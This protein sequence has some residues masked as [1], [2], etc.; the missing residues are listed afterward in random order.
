MPKPAA[1]KQRK[2]VKLD[3]KILALKKKL[4]EEAEKA[5]AER[6]ARLAAG[7]VPMT[8]E[9]RREADKEQKR[10][11]EEAAA[12]AAEF[13][14]TKIIASQI[15]QSAA[16]SAAAAEA[17]QMIAAAAL[18]GSHARKGHKENAA[19]ARNAYLNYAERFHRNNPNYN[20][21]G[22]R[23]YTLKGKFAKK[24]AKGGKRGLTRRK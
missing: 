13:E 10:L 6:S 11:E 21:G 2:E 8:T 17:S 12:A 19:A 9:E 24:P 16:R 20:Q 4:E 7:I 3:P 5:E 1:K 18:A 23:N 22:P 14:A 15:V